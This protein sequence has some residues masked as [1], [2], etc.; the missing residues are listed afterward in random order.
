[1]ACLNEQSYAPGAAIMFNMMML[2]L[3]V[4]LASKYQSY[5]GVLFMGQLMNV[6]RLELTLDGIHY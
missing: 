6:T 4:F 2:V 5:P 3:Q 1:M